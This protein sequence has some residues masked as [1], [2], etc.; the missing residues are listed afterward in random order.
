MTFDPV[1]GPTVFRP[2]QGWNWWRWGG[3]SHIQKGDIQTISNTNPTLLKPSICRNAKDNIYS[4]GVRVSSFCNMRSE[5]AGK[6][7]NRVVMIVLSTVSSIK[8]GDNLNYVWLQWIQKY[9]FQASLFHSN[10]CVRHAQYG[11]KPVM[12][13]GIQVNKLAPTSQSTPSLVKDSKALPK[14]RRLCDL[15]LSQP[16]DIV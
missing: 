14:I 16:G 2:D 5:G 6:I 4:L 9:R 1:H 11:R 13:F 10:A 3:V 8:F 15:P 7:E 12:H